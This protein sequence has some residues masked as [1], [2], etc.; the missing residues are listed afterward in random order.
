MKCQACD[1]ESEDFGV[2][3]VDIKGQKEVFQI[4]F[5]DECLE[6]TETNFIVQCGICGMFG[7]WNKKDFYQKHKEAYEKECPELWRTWLIWWHKIT[8]NPIIFL[9]VP[10]CIYCQRDIF[11]LE[12]RISYPSIDCWRN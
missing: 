6:K 5:C 7:W 3:S 2:L 10:M 11:V 8:R 4:Y 9:R 12:N 1:N